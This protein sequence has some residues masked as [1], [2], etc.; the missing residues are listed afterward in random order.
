M[1][2][3]RKNELWAVTESRGKFLVYSGSTKAAKC[4]SDE[5]FDLLDSFERKRGHI[6]VRLPAKEVI[7][8]AEVPSL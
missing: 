5:L 7:A 4:V 8:L 3:Q 1:S 2:A 6:M